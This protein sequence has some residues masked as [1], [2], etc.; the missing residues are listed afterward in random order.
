MLPTFSRYYKELN[1]K[2]VALENLLYDR[3]FR[4]LRK[5][6]ARHLQTGDTSNVYVRERPAR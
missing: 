1:N 3:R 2:I 6:S 4:S 5:S